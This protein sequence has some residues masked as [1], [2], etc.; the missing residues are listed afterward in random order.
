MLTAKPTDTVAELAARIRE[1][2]AQPP[3]PG[4]IVTGWMYTPEEAAEMMISVAQQKERYD[5]RGASAE[6]ARR[7]EAP[8]RE[9]ITAALD[10]FDFGSTGGAKIERASLCARREENADWRF[11]SSVGAISDD[12]FEEAA[13]A[14]ADW[15]DVNAERLSA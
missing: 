8:M 1:E 14:I 6:H 2:R 4:Q 15:F 12:D 10:G 7:I 9:R 11:L 5:R 3:A 13:Q